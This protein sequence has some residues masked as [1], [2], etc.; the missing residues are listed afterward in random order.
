MHSLKL[1]NG[2]I[3]LLGDGAEGVGVGGVAGVGGAGLQTTEKNAWM[4]CKKR[5]WTMI[6]KMRTRTRTK[7]L[8]G[9]SGPFRSGVSG[10]VV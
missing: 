2:P 4:E 8:N 1:L 10:M 7:R 9:P 5:L 6:R 3:T